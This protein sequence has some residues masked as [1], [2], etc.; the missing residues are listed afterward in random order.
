M[1][2]KSLEIYLTDN[3]QPKYMGDARNLAK[4]LGLSRDDLRKFGPLYSMGTYRKAIRAKVSEL[5]GLPANPFTPIPK[6]YTCTQCKRPRQ[7]GFMF[8]PSCGNKF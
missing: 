8:C 5:T 2:H 6:T 3:S 4:K 1:D 7:D